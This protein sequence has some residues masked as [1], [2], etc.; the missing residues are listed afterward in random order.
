MTGGYH[1]LLP[2]LWVCLLA[3]MLSDE[4]SIYSAQ[5]ASR[6]RSPAHKGSFVRE[7]LS[8]VQVSQ[9]LTPGLQV[10]TLYP[11]DSLDTVIDRLSDEPYPVLPVVDRDNRLLGVVDLEEV[12]LASKAPGLRPLVLAAD[13]MHVRIQPLRPEDQLDRALELFVEND[14]LALPIVNDMEQRKVIGMVRRYE[15]ASTY[16]RHVQGR[17]AP[18]RGSQ[19]KSTS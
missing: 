7:V 9:F 12:H 8:G 5:V 17:S 2:A 1:L 4:Q 15:I 13:L 19:D 3:F 18:R 16:L 14:L 11:D 6:S 10:P